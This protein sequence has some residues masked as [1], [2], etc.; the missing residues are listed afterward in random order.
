MFHFAR[1]FVFSSQ[2]YR[3][4][5][6]QYCLQ[7]KRCKSVYETIVLYLEFYNIMSQYVDNRDKKSRVTLCIPTR[8]VGISIPAWDSLFGCFLNGVTEDLVSRIHIKCIRRQQSLCE[9]IRQSNVVTPFGLAEVPSLNR[10]AWH[11]HSKPWLCN[12]RRSML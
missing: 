4:Q 11:C 12:K 10:H 2:K 6:K 7:K 8:N 5:F 9:F 3:R 1:G